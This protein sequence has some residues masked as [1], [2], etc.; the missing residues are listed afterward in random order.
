M[1]PANEDIDTFST[2][3][4]QLAPLVGVPFKIKR[5]SV[6]GFLFLFFQ[7]KLSYADLNTITAQGPLLM[8]LH[9][10][11]GY[12]TLVQQSSASFPTLSSHARV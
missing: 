4:D 8:N 2:L 12:I 1:K 6:Q 7:I 3:S 10:V 9:T 11:R 5:I